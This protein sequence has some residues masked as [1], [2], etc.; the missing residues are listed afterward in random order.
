MP[1]QEH[2]DTSC[3]DVLRRHNRSAQLGDGRKERPDKENRQGD[4]IPVAR[5]D[6]KVSRC[7][8]VGFVVP[9]MPPLFPAAAG[10]VLSGRA[11]GMTSWRSLMSLPIRRCP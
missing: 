2:Q 6:V 7:A 3:A 8:A 10:R 5:A 9:E 4:P 11:E 1:L